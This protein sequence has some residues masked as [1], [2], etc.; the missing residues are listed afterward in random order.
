[1]SQKFVTRVPGNELAVLYKTTH[2]NDAIAAIYNEFKMTSNKSLWLS[3]N[4]EMLSKHN[5]NVDK[6]IDVWRDGVDY[7]E[8]AF[9]ESSQTS[10]IELSYDA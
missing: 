10:V 4:R 1:M 8:V 5:I 7:E 6:L 2:A 3:E 9:I